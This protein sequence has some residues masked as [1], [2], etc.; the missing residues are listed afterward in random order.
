MVGSRA[1]KGLWLVL[2]WTLAMGL[3]SA[4]FA[5]VAIDSALAAENTT[6]SGLT[7]RLITFSPKDELFEWFGHAVLEARNTSTG[8]AL[9]F[10]F[11]GFTFR[12]EDL[13]LFVMGQFWFWSTVAPTDPAL[14]YY[15]QGG[16]HIVYQSLTLTDRQKQR[17]W[18][19][20]TAAV[21]PENR[22]YRYDHFLDNCATRLRDQIDHALDGQLR[23]QTTATSELTF[24]EH[25]QRLTA[26]RPGLNFVL[27]YVLSDGVDRPISRWESM[28]LPD[29]LMLEIQK[30]VVLPENGKTPIPLVDKRS[31]EINQS[32][33]PLFEGLTA[34]PPTHCRELAAGSG[35]G[36]LLAIAAWGWLR[37]RRWGRI[38][39]GGLTALFGIVFGGLGLIL[40]FMAV[41][42]DHHDTYW[43]ENLFLAGPLTL[44][45]LPLGIGL[46]WNRGRQLFCVVTVIC[47]LL[48]LTGLVL[49]LLPAF[50]QVNGQQLRVLLPSLLVI[51]TA[52]AIGWYRR[53]NSR[54]G[55][56]GGVLSRAGL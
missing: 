42:A 20:L 9:S 45:L 28:F 33:S 10:G 5:R 21:Q 7:F 46:A 15:R 43:N 52:G 12:P 11:G 18:Q 29:R 26:H 50:D 14:V 36:L 31:D 16:R 47:G 56:G 35:F 37:G 4:G 1:Y 27:N 6:A 34:P 54:Y 17:L 30:A 23:R 55:T 19:G 22:L 24:R 32:P 51:G 41:I 2:L 40:F 39:Y 13:M 53:S 8:E 49:K 48:A 3:P 25:I 38:G 44:L